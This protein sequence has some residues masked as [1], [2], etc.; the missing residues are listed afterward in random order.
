MSQCVCLCVSLHLCLSSVFMCKRKASAG[1]EAPPQ[2]FICSDSK[3]CSPCVPIYHTE[4]IVWLRPDPT[5]RTQSP[6]RQ[7]CMSKQYSSMNSQT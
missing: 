4:L 1:L 2:M 5:E 7:I 6:P 3:V